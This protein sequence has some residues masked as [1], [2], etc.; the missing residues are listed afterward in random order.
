VIPS[1]K[2]TFDEVYLVTELME[3]DLFNIIKSKQTLL[4]SHIK[5]FMY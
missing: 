2:E 1:N 3:S 4:G 5:W